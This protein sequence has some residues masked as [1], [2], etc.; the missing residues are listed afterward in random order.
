[1]EPL[2]SVWAS[3]TTVTVAT[4]RRS[5]DSQLQPAFGDGEFFSSLKTE[6][7]SRKVYRTREQTRADVFDDVERL[8]NPT[9]RHPTLGHVSPIEFEK[10][11]EA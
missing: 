1:M 10:A 8:Y 6:R 3:A 7:T 5:G 4:R 11:Q 2:A 9:R